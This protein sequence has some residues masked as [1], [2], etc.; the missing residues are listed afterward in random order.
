MNEA[1]QPASLFKQCTMCEHP[2][3]SRQRFL[4]DPE[5]V[6]VGYQSYLPDPDLGLFLFNHLSCE[7][8]LA[9]EATAFSDLYSGPIYT[10]QLTGTAECKKHCLN[11]SVLRTCPSRCACAYVREVLQI[12]RQWP[13]SEGPG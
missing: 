9:L 6:V 10:E 7:T 1:Q 3:D 4:E 2:W 5:V 8:T 12:V 13:K 11:S